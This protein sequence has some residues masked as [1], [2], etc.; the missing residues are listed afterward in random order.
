MEIST[1]YVDHPWDG[2]EFHA[3]SLQT[4]IV[5]DK[6]WNP[7]LQ[8]FRLSKVLVTHGIGAEQLLMF[9]LDSLRRVRSDRSNAHD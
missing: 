6:D 7:L 4:S 8:D 5:M 9:H 1:P 3:H 2:Y